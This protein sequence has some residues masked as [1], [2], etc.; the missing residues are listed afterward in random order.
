MLKDTFSYLILRHQQKMLPTLLD[1][2][3]DPQ[4]AAQPIAGMNH[5]AWILGHILAVEHRIGGG[6]LGANWKIVLDPGWWDVY[7]FGSIPQSDR[8]RYKSKD[9]Y[10]TCLDET[11]NMIAA[12]CEEA[13]DADLDKAVP[14]AEMAKFFPTLSIA[15]GAAATHRAYHSGQLAIWRKAMGLPH[16]GM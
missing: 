13:S 8:S 3:A 4:L 1:G 2:I 6:L 5:P 14:H 15:L 11:A 7:G 9:F 12:F 16:A 10:M